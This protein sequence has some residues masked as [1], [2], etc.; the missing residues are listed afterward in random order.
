MD[1]IR[2]PASMNRAYGA[3]AGLFLLR[4]RICLGKAFDVL[5]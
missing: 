1:S 3:A 4:C 5:Q 2:L